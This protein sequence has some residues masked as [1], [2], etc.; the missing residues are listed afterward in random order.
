M[1]SSRVFSQGLV[2]GSFALT[3]TNIKG[4][5]HFACYNLSALLKLANSRTCTHRFVSLKRVK[6]VTYINA[7]VE[8]LLSLLTGEILAQGKEGSSFP[9]AKGAPVKRNKHL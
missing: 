8:Y 9:H 4:N 5:L 3:G 7:K 2:P 6:H 1:N